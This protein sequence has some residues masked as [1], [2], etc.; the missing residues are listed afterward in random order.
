MDSKYSPTLAFHASNSTPWMELIHFEK[1]SSAL[2]HSLYGRH[3]RGGRNWVEWFDVRPLASL[4]SDSSVGMAFFEG[5]WHMVSVKNDKLFHTTFATS[6][7]H[8][9]VQ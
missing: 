8:P 4:G 7:I 2:Y 3:R 1:G 6:E 5:C 9:R